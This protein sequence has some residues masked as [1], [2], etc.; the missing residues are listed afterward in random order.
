MH[1]ISYSVNSWSKIKWCK[2]NSL[3]CC[4]RKKTIVLPNKVSFLWW[5]FTDWQCHQ[6]QEKDNTKHFTVYGIG[7]FP[8]TRYVEWKKLFYLSLSQKNIS[9][10]FIFK[11]PLWLFSFHLNCF[12]A[13]TGNFVTFIFNSLLPFPVF[14][15]N[16][17]YYMLLFL[18]IANKGIHFLL[19][20]LKY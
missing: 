13:S 17:W 3:W 7:L 9:S 1:I 16:S 20:K 14:F 4:W 8:Q 5:S 10:V 18:L 12:S 19:L 11:L 15:L 6:W 2:A